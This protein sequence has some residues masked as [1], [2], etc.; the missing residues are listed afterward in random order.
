MK[1]LELSWDI[2]TLKQPAGMQDW[3]QNRLNMVFEGSK[4]IPFPGNRKKSASENQE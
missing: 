3:E 1:K 2:Q 4:I